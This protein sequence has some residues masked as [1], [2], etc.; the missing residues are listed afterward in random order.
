MMMGMRGGPGDKDP[1]L[2]TCTNCILPLL[3]TRAYDIKAY[4]LTRQPGWT[5]PASTFPRE[6]PAGASKEQF[7]LMMQNLLAERFKLAIHRDQK[8]MQVY[9][10]VVAKG[11]L[12]GEGVGTRAAE[13]LEM[14]R[15]R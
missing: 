4:Q 5:R 13:R 7:R 14:T 12:E 6:S 3:I 1:E 2:Y 9:E 8:E 11:G 10:M 15:F